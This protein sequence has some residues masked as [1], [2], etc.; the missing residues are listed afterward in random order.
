MQTESEVVF[1]EEAP[2]LPG[3]RFRHVVAEDAPALFAVHARCADHDQIDRLSSIEYAPT[4]NDL[5][6]Q[7]T[8]VFQ[9]GHAPN[10]LIA[11][12]NEDV[13]GYCR[14]NWWREVDGIWLYLTIGWVVPSWRGK[15]LGAAMLHWAEERIRQLAAEHPNEGK[16]EFGSNA[17]STERETT[18]LLLGVGYRVVYTVLD[19][20]LSDFSLVP[21]PKLPEGLELRPLTPEHYRAV[22]DS[23]QDSYD[24]GRY[25][26]ES[27]EDHF[28]AYFHNPAHEPA[29]WQVAWA[30]E[31]VVGQVLC[32]IENGRGEVYEVS[33]RPAWR[34]RGLARGLLAY[35]LR[36][37]Q[38]R[39]VE[40][41]RLHTVSE[42]PTQAKNLYGSVGFHVRKE[43]PRYRKPPGASIQKTRTRSRS[44]R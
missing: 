7:L 26:E 42:F 10:W 27:T 22:W 12:V 40:A 14:I 30:G 8:T 28:R 2:A 19:M 35:G 20:E 36:A 17:S 34:R 18:S 9:Q 1:V 3:L 29:L 4:Q 43:F 16:W 11:Q 37:L 44:S 33:V 31:E 41:V 23:I 21:E 25:G 5:A 24:K 13:I 15:G 6:Q 39:G 38:Q 32:K